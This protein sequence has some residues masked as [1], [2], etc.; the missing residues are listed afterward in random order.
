MA[1]P[2]K[3]EP[4]ADTLRRR[5]AR[6]I[7][8]AK[9]KKRKTRKDKGTVKVIPPRVTKAKMRIAILFSGGLITPIA[10]ALEMTR[11]EVRDHIERKGWEDIKAVYDEQRERVGDKAEK[12]IQDVMGNRLDLRAAA[13]AA[14]WYLSKIHQDRGFREK[15]TVALEG[16]DTPIQVEGMVDIEKLNLPLDVRKALL[17]AMENEEGDTE[18]DDNTQQGTD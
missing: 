13:D 17:E 14:K 5:R 9:G 18:D 10:D 2:R 6:L 4:D 12:T 8:K 11:V 1:K 7:K 16:G 15:R 3:P